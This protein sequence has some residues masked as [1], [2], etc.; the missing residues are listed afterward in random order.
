MGADYLVWPTRE[1]GLNFSDKTISAAARV[2]EENEHDLK[3]ISK[4]F[5]KRRTKNRDIIGK[6]K[7]SPN[8]DWGEEEV[9]YTWKKGESKNAG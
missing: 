9:I 8:I 5:K 6:R 7:K 3:R 1:K 2:E 4:Q